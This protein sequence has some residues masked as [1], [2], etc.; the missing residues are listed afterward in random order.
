MPKHTGYSKRSDTRLTVPHVP[1]RAS[2]Y[3]STYLGQ[4][5]Q[6]FLVLKNL[7]ERFLSVDLSR[8]EIKYPA[9]LMGY[10]FLALLLASLSENK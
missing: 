5:A 10:F 8:S 1:V 3:P 2:T 4:K 7:R 6:G 9:K